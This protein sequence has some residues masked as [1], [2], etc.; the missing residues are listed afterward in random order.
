MRHLKTR[1]TISM[2]R[3]V[4]QIKTKKKHNFMSITQ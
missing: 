3:L 4:F 2:V 1:K